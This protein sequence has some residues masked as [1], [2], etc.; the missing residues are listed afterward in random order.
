[1]AKKRRF[2]KQDSHLIQPNSEIDD[3]YKGKDPE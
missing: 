2:R 3:K 1:M